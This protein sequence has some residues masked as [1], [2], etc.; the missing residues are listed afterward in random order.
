MVKTTP[1]AAAAAEPSGSP[2]QAEAPAVKEAVLGP[3]AVKSVEAPPPG[4]G[5]LEAA[6][7]RPVERARGGGSLS[8]VHFAFDS[9][10]LGPEARTVLGANAEYLYDHPTAAVLIEGHCDE[11]GTTEY[12]LALGER[13]A[14]SALTYLED[15]GISQDRLGVVTYG[16]EMPLDRGQHEAAWARSPAPENP[17][18]LLSAGQ[19]A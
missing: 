14:R 18:R 2:T 7:A 10:S 12:N 13:R 4:I 3:V 17:L 16:E 15:L 9:A 6:P 5:A 11:R 19:F 1:D 8:R